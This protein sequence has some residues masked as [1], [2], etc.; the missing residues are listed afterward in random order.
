MKNVIDFAAYVSERSPR[1]TRGHGPLHAARTPCG[2]TRWQPSIDGLSRILADLIMIRDLYDKHQRQLPGLALRAL[3][4]LY[5][6]NRNEQADLIRKISDRVRLLGGNSLVMSNHVVEL[7]MIPRAPREREAVPAQI[8]R[9]LKAHAAVLR[10]V[11]SL[12]AKADALGDLGTSRMLRGEV[13]RVQELH[14][15]TLASY[16][17]EHGAADAASDSPRPV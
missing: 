11:L 6:R 17:T 15:W 7:T 5:I 10:S 12:A 3:E 1:S 13:F 8:S 14:A 9:L 16:L 2:A 4:L